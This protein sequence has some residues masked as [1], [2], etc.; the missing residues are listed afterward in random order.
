[1]YCYSLPQEPKQT[2]QCWH[3]S[4]HTTVYFRFYLQHRATYKL[5]IYGL[6]KPSI[7]YKIS[8]TTS[9]RKWLYV[10]LLRYVIF[11][12]FSLPV[13]WLFCSIVRM[14]MKLFH[15]MPDACSSFHSWYIDHLLISTLRHLDF[16]KDFMEKSVFY[17]LYV[18]SFITHF[19]V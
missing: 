12:S 9:T 3:N 11:Y 7:R 6:S 5:N 8:N 10:L 16:S 14:D 19:W 13:F 17:T 1:M 2:L 18:L 4:S 15:L